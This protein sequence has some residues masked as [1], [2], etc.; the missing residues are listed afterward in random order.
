MPA[1][2]GSKSGSFTIP[3]S[4][5]TAAN[6][7]YRIRL[8][9]TDS[10]GLTHSTFRDVNP[11]TASLTLQT[12]PAG[13]QVLLDGQPLTAPSTFTG[14]AG[15]VRSLQAPSPQT[16]A[17]TDYEFVSWSDGGAR[18]HDISTPAT[19]RTYTAAFRVV[20]SGS[21]LVCPASVPSRAKYTATVNTG[22]SATDWVAQ[23]TP[24]SPDR[25]WIG[26]FK[27][28]PLPR[29]AAVTLTA[30]AAA[31]TYELRLFA[32]D[33]MTRIGS[34]TFQVT[35]K[36]ALSI[37]DVTV[38]EGNAGTVGATFT[39]SLSAASTT[40]VTVKWGTAN[41]TAVRPSDYAYGTGTLTF[42]PG[43]VTKTVTV[44]VKGNTVRE[45]NETFF[46]NLSAPVGAT[47]A[48]RQG[49]GTI[50]NDDGP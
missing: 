8:T 36:P 31:G 21:A 24:G 37:D 48:D 49:K 29:P 28:V 35:G 5:E 41:G 46:V 22:S 14:V 7:W 11:R 13:L 4:G 26:A 15:I 27:Y 39:V 6:V 23:Y 45:P 9:V 3:T 18:A 42:A 16:L 38:T 43:E 2:T 34:C 44:L 33:T 32:N 50:T 25:P 40:T 17:G 30:P 19:N 20:S 1:T 10:G 12:S 47:I